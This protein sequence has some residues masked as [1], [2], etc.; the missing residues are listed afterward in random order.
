M[1]GN[2]GG[3]YYFVVA[4]SSKR[5]IWKNS[6]LVRILLKMVLTH[7][8]AYL[9]HWRAE[10]SSLSST[11]SRCTD[12]LVQK[13]SIRFVKIWNLG[14]N[15]IFTC[16]SYYDHDNDKIWMYEKRIIYVCS[17]LMKQKGI[18]FLG[19]VMWVPSKI[20]W[21]SKSHYHPFLISKLLHIRAICIYLHF[22]CSIYWGKARCSNDIYYICAIV[23]RVSLS[24]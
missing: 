7:V 6:Y 12:N 15:V 24:P 9:W 20:S 11:L 4:F 16:W 5:N 8:I 14:Y 17:H 2:L 23:H 3:L 10:K 22:L 18:L 21:C 13:Y 1:L 19:S